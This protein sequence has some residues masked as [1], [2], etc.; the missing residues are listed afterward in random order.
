VE[1][2]QH[3]TVAADVDELVRVPARR[4]GARFGLAVADHAADDQIGVVE[5][6]AEGV[7]EGVAE[8]TTL[9]DRTRG[10]GGDVARDAARIR[11][12]GEEPGE[13]VDV[14]AD[15]RIDLGIGALEIR[16]RDH[17]RP[18]VA[19]P[20]DEDRVQVALADHAIHVGIHEIEAGRGAPMPQQS[21]LDLID[22]QRF[23][24]Q[25]VRAQVDLAHREVVRRAPIGIDQGEG[26]RRERRIARRCEDG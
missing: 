21:R 9:V 14:A 1:N 5:G 7:Q 18:A 16:V 2:G 23:P 24:E 26:V 22:R 13:A 8:L 4:E 10:L 12:L 3:R 15:R 6:G 17:A 11:E 25:R 19:G 20:C